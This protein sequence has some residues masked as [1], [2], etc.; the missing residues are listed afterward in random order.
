[1][2]LSHAE[3]MDTL[4]QRVQVAGSQ[5]K[6]AS[7]YGMSVAFI[8]SV[9]KGRKAPGPRLLDRLGYEPLTVYRPTHDHDMIPQPKE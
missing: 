6:L 9:L 3:L 4:R 7:E 2:I 1:M 5:R 8:S